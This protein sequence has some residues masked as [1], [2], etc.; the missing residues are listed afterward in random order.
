MRT[1]ALVTRR[2][3]LG[4][5][6][7]G[8]GACLAGCAARSRAAPA[9]SRPRL[10]DLHHHMLPPVYLASARER[11][12]AQGQGFLPTPVLV[13]TPEASLAEMDATDVATAILSI[14]TPG[15]SFGDT[16]AARRL[17][18]ECNEYAAR[19]VPDHPGRFGFFAV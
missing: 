19:L 18:R 5:L 8:A 17:A 12:I 7:A 16:A 13:W 1:P 2:S 3:F 6:A 10:V 15:V 11:V 9:S 4:T 14:S